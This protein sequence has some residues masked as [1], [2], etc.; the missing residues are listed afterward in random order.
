MVILRE[1]QTG[2]GRHDEGLKLAIGL[3]PPAH[4]IAPDPQTPSEEQQGLDSGHWDEA[5]HVILEV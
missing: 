4:C 3:Q 2:F 5:L 1:R